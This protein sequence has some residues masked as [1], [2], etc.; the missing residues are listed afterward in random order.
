M[1]ISNHS[2]LLK[3]PA[4][5]LLCKD[6]RNSTATVLHVQGCIEIEVTLPEK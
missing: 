2:T 6:G 4:F 3:T 5:L 1:W